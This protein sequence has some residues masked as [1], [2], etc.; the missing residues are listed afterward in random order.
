MTGFEEVAIVLEMFAA[1]NAYWAR[2]FESQREP[3]E[4]ISASWVSARYAERPKDFEVRAVG[5]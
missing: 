4:P 1:A 3:E 5:R 2:W